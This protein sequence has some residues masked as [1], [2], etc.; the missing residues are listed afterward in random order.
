MRNH[1]EKHRDIAR[2][3]L[4]ST[5]R[6]A[7][8]DNRAGVRN[9]ERAN[10]RQLLHDLRVGIDFDD[11]EGDCAWR[12][13]R[14]LADM[15]EDRRGADKVGPLLQWAERTIANSRHLTEAS[16]EDREAHFRKVLPPGLIGDH[17]ISHLWRVLDDDRRRRWSRSRRVVETRN[18]DVGLVE[19]IVAAGRHGE[20][21]RRLRVELGGVVKRAVHL[22]AERLIDDDHPAPGALLPRRTT[23]EH[24]RRPVRFLLGAHDIE[25][26]VRQAGWDGLKVVRDLHAELNDVANRYRER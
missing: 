14:D 24:H 13:R 4:P 19:E 10:E 2:S 12:N 20:L 9:R 8:R 26:F 5:A 21:N 16:P 23:T 7:A 17:A 1:N 25:A 15:I 3:V 11:F 22:P 6:K 18:P